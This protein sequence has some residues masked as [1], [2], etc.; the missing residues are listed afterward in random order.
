MILNGEVRLFHSTLNFLYFN[1]T[2]QILN[3]RRIQCR[4]IW[5]CTVCQ[6]PNPGFTINL[7]YTAFWRQSDKN[8]AA[9]NSH[10]L[11]FVHTRGLISLIKIITW[12][13]TLRKFWCA[14]IVNSRSKKSIVKSTGRHWSDAV[15]Y[16]IRTGPIL[17]AQACLADNLQQ[18]RCLTPRL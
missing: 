3:R 10:Y 15:F 14:S 8:S 4:L 16:G 11:D 5:F 6:R 7:L 18:I 13:K 9:I 12:T 2:V 17:F 1:Q